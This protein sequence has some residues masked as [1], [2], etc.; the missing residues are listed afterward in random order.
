MRAFGN[1]QAKVYVLNA[2]FAAMILMLSSISSS[3]LL[4][5]KWTRIVDNGNSASSRQSRFGQ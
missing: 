2:M 5:Q 4:G 3:T 1:R